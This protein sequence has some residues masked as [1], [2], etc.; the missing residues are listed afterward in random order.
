MNKEKAFAQTLEKVKNLARE[1][2]NMVT[3]EQVMEAFEKLE[4]SGD[5]MQMVYDYLLSNKIGIGQFLD[6][7]DYLT[8]KEQDYL[9][10]Y[11]GEVRSIGQISEGEKEAVTLSAMA[12]DPD[13]Q[14]RLIE[15][16]LREIPEIAKLYAGQGVFLEDLIGEGN[17]ALTLAVTMLGSLER[18]EEA[19]GMI[20]KMVMDAMENFIQENADIKKANSKLEAKVQKVAK[21]AHELSLEYRRKVTVEELVEESGMSEKLIRDALR[22]CGNQIED[23]EVDE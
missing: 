12:G 23:I 10:E 11:L 19:S 18:A 16:Y 9:E 21:K 4:L 22:M 2:G 6:P 3:Q 7:E 8:Q 15:V 1:Q 5:Q 13:A 17:V 14:G 20:G